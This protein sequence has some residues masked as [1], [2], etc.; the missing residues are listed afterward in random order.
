MCVCVC[1]HVQRLHV[2]MLIYAHVYIINK[3]AKLY[4][5]NYNTLF[6]N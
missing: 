2:F 6:S 3:I 4:H 1:T 5:K